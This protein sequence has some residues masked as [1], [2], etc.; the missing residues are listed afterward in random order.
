[1]PKL[2]DVRQEQNQEKPS[3]RDKL[4]TAAKQ[5]PE[6]KSPVKSKTHDMEL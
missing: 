4:R 6:K 3:I 1:M 5:Q 2:E